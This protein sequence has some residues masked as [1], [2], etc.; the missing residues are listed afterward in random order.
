M[1]IFSFEKQQ[2]IS[3]SSDKLSVDH[4]LICFKLPKGLQRYIFS[5]K[6]SKIAS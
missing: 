1:V 5:Q 4:Y 3:Y 6:K 2:K